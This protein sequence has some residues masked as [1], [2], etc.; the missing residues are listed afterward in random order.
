LQVKVIVAAGLMAAMLAGGWVYRPAAPEEPARN[1]AAQRE[2]EIA[3]PPVD[4]AQVAAVVAPA[5][6]VAPAPVAEPEAV[7][8]PAPVEVIAQ[9]ETPPTMLSESVKQYLAEQGWAERVGTG[10]GVWVSVE[11]QRFIVLRDGEVLF[12]AICATA[13]NGVGSESGS[14]KTPLGWHAVAEKFGDGAPWGQVFRSRV[15]TREVWK[16]GGNTV[17]DLVLTRVLWLDGAEPGKNKGKDAA[18]RNVDSKERCIY[19]HGTNAEER[20]GTPSSH[21]CVR[22]LNDDVITAFA[23]IPLATPVL[24][25]E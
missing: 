1:P 21:G 4:L 18:G 25:T 13:T 9:E 24:I 2:V 3:L 17:E 8:E 15:A 23:L 11:H 10:M 20:I 6:P 12:N 16:P 5:A 14:Q 19:I 7:T 22:L